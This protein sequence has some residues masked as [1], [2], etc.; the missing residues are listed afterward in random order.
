MPALL[1]NGP[2]RIRRVEHVV[3]RIKRRF[4]FGVEPWPAVLQ[5]GMP[6]WSAAEALFAVRR[7][8]AAGHHDGATAQVRCKTAA[9]P[10]RH[11]SLQAMDACG[12][13][14]LRQ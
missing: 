8:D 9:K 13:I 11:Q 7:D 10:D 3:G 12:W 14:L 4:C 6:V 5:R 2:F 1:M